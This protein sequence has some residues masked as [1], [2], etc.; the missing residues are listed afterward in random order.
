M[1][2]TDQDK[3]LR[4]AEDGGRVSVTVPMSPDMKQRITKAAGRNELST[5]RYIRK[6]IVFYMAANNE[7]SIPG[8]RKG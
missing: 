2:D 3:A 5:V 6:A 8:P 4:A 1:P 7:W